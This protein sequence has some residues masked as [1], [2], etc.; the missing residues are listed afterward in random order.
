[1]RPPAAWLSSAKG[2]PHLSAR[3]GYGLLPRSRWSI[4]TLPSC[5]APS[6]MPVYAA[7][8]LRIRSHLVDQANT[9]LMALHSPRS[10][11]RMSP[12]PR[13]TV[14][15]LWCRQ[16]SGVMAPMPRRRLSP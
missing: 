2:D 13:P 9:R 14:C 5:I 11:A 4:E 1:M 8:L 6:F 16:K 15:R 7:G 10:V 12:P 3:S